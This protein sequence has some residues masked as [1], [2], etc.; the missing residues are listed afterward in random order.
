M[1]R[2]LSCRP[3]GG[4][5]CKKNTACWHWSN[6]RQRES[7]HQTACRDDFKVVKTI[8]DQ[9]AASVSENPLAHGSQPVMPP[10]I[11]PFGVHSPGDADDFAFALI[12]TLHHPSTKPLSRIG[13]LWSEVCHIEP[14]FGVRQREILH[15]HRHAA[16]SVRR[17]IYSEARSTTDQRQRLGTLAMPNWLRL[18][19]A[20]RTNCHAIN[21]AVPHM[22]K[23]QRLSP[24]AIGFHA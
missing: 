9:E 6:A 10:S 15:S 14:E 8:G 12:A 11:P 13:P 5:H 23:G 1:V 16:C 18:S 3:T 21:I 2:Y 4:G 24:N 20:S 19:R 22:L 7:P 17:G